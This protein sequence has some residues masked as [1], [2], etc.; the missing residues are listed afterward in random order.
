MAV[1]TKWLSLALHG[2]WSSTAKILADLYNEDF[3]RICPI[4]ALS[5]DLPLIAIPPVYG[6]LRGP[7]G[8][9]YVSNV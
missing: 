4:Q 3:S 9:F 1:P 7:E 8:A 6:G 5:Y 2:E